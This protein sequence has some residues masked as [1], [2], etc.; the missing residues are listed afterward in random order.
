MAKNSTE[1]KCFLGI[2]ESEV[3]TFL[4][5]FSSKSC[6]VSIN[7]MA[8]YFDLCAMAAAEKGLKLAGGLSAE[9]IRC[10]D[11]VFHEYLRAGGAVINESARTYAK[12]KVA[13]LLD[14]PL[15]LGM[16]LRCLD[17]KIEAHIINE[18][19]AEKT[20]PKTRQGKA[21]TIDSR[22]RLY[23]LQTPFTE[24]DIM[25]LRSAIIPFSQ[26]DPETTERIINGLNAL[27]PLS[28]REAFFSEAGAG[29]RRGEYCE[30]LEIIRRAL[31]PTGGNGAKK[32]LR[33]RYCRY[34]SELSLE[35]FALP[36]GTMERIVNPVRV[37]CAG[38]R[39]YLV[40]FSD[41][42][43]DARPAGD[44]YPSGGAKPYL[45]NYRIDR[46]KDVECLSEDAI[47]YAGFLRGMDSSIVMLRKQLDS[48]GNA[49][50]TDRARIEKARGFDSSGFPAAR[51]RQKHPIMYSGEPNKD[52]PI[53]LKCRTSLINSVVDVFGT[54]VEIKKTADP[55]TVIVTIR[56]TPQA[57]VAL[58]ALEYCESC[59]VLEPMALR[60]RMASAAKKLMNA[61]CRDSVQK[62]G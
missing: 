58:W 49:P 38:G 50:R 19:R 26:T 3:L 37:M 56:E 47:S 60:E 13:A 52:E 61:Y 45:I 15:F 42:A 23:Y 12:R 6:P 9:D 29:K 24:S 7:D 51:Y 36:D 32:K 18:R 43:G 44:D 22:A 30:N 48:A 57:G 62:S 53:L 27:T 31:F 14:R 41:L 59:E 16:T 54:D 17:P 11:R 28:N 1:E 21:P 8:V 4:I 35:P 39:Y 10:I 20:A 34:N 55:E 25:A 2:S 46:M 40:A 33:F 5:K